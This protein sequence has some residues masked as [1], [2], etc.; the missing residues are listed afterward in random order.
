MDKKAIT[1]IILSGGKSRRMGVDKSLMLLKGKPLI[2]HA[3]DAI[4]PLCERVI[5]SS[6]NPIYDFTSCEVWP[7]TLFIKAPI[8]GIY[9][10]LKGSQ[11]DINIILSCDVP[12]IP[13]E[14]FEYLLSN[15]ENHNIILPRH[16]NFLEPLCG[17]YKKS[18]IPVLEDAINKQNYKLHTLIDSTSCLSLEISPIQSFYTSSMFLNVNTL[19]DFDKLTTL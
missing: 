12:L 4:R 15:A 19:A 11:T 8:I 14:L 18:V 17:I 9:S 10:C 16:D 7:D 3:I 5:I 1:G 2:Q 6:N 13:T